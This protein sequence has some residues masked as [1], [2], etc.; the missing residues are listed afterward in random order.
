[1]KKFKGLI[2]GAVALLFTSEAYTPV[3]AG[4]ADFA[5]PYIAIRAGAHGGAMD[6]TAT[7]NNSEVTSGTLGKTWGDVGVQVG[8]SIP[9]GSSFLLGLDFSLNPVEQIQKLRPKMEYGEI[10]ALLGRFQF[11]KEMVNTSLDNLSGGE[12][13][14]IALLK[15]LLEENNLLLLDEPTNHLDTDA[16]EALEEALKTYLGTL[17]IVSHDRWFLDQLCTTIWNLDGQGNVE[18][19][20]GNY[21]CFAKIPSSVR[22]DLNS[23]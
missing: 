10:R 21:S 11:T 17:V 18:V 9:I 8:W 1:M 5:G 22:K 20:P 16:K 6:G 12:R 7:N 4:S 23:R 13:A 14:R 3:I 15:L 19:Y 2:L